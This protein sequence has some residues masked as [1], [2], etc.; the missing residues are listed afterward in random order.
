ML[1]PV[2]ALSQRRLDRRV[3]KHHTHPPLPTRI[4]NISTKNYW[5]NQR[6]I[7]SSSLKLKYGWLNLLSL[8][9]TSQKHGKIQICKVMKSK[10]R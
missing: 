6:K 3:M 1:S 7:I 10:S 2:I 5:I 9:N 8:R 4:A